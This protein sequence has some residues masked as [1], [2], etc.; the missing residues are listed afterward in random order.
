MICPFCSA[1]DDKVIDSRASEGGR[2]I[3]RRRECLR[4]GKRFTTYERVEQTARLMVIKKDGTRVPFNRENIYRGVASAIGKRPIPEDAKRTLVADI[5]DEL[6]REYDREVPST[7]IGDRV[8]AKLRALDDVAYIRFA[9]EYQQFRSVEDLMDELQMLKDSPK[10][11]RNQQ[12]LF[13]ADGKAIDKHA[14][15]SLPTNST[16]NSN[17]GPHQ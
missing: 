12:N 13:G 17:T 5:D 10:D 8:M 14:A 3:R 11:A 1:N 4:C 6:H 7:V 2:V 15:P 16:S 9:S